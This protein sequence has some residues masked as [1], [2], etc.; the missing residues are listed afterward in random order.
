MVV[1]ETGENKYLS[2]IGF[3]EQATAVPVQLAGQAVAVTRAK[4]WRAA[5]IQQRMACA[6]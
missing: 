2:P 4:Y 3:K 5:R 1:R 6:Q